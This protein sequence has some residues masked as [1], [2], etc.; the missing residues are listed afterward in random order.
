[1]PAT[2]TTIDAIL[3]EVYEDRIQ[4][5]TQNE[6]IALKRVEQTS[7]G[8][9]ETTGGK[10]VDFPVRVR[11]NHGIGYRA[12][13]SQLPASG[14]QGYAEVHVPLRYGYGRFRMT[15]QAMQ[16]AD[17]NEKAFAKALDRE[18]DY[19]KEDLVKDSARIIYGNGSGLVA[20]LDDATT[21]DTHAV[22]NAQ[23]VE[24]GMIVDIVNM[25]TGAITQANTTVESVDGLNVT[26]ADSFTAATTLGVYRQ[27]N[28]NLEPSGFAALVDD[29][30][31][32]HTLD[33]SVE[34]KW[35]SVVKG[36]GGTPRALS[37]G[38][39]IETCDDVRRNG[40]TVKVIFTSLGVRRAYFNLLTQ[41]R[42]FTNTKE[43]EGGF[44][45]LAFNYGKEIPVVEDVDAPPET[46]WFVDDSDFTVY[47]TKDWHFADEDGNVMKW[48]TD[49][50]TWEGFMRKY[51]E[52]GVHARNHHARLD[53]L[54]EG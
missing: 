36:N 14:Q 39:M 18:M 25:T 15:A 5:L 17:S 19:L 21:S 30:S 51:W 41:Q 31:E 29:D 27:G 34:P 7:D 46:A 23:Y 48:V 38:L 28:F 10:Y 52:V 42:R 37:E 40:G 6:V 13:G 33:P 45:G 1:M 26:F 12:E 54:I 8:V 3:K 9:T 50:D 11:R 24:E 32:L 44:T 47:R 2:L 43:F 4:D 49:Y 35:A 53:D 22:V 20:A 16:L